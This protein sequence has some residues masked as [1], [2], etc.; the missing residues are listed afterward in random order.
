M[1]GIANAVRE[2]EVEAEKKE[3]EAAQIRKVIAGMKG[4][5]IIVGDAASLPTSTEYVGKGILEAAKLFAKSVG[6]PLTTRELADGMTQ[7]GWTTRSHNVT[8]TIY[9]TLRNA[10]K[11]WH[12]NP[13]GEWEYI[14]TR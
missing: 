7:K 2:L 12:R 1:S 3:A 8:A 10:D 5:V 9:A 6:K 4:L 13:R 11:D 14:G